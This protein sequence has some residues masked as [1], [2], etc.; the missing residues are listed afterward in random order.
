MIKPN[1][2]C[3]PPKPAAMSALPQAGRT[4]Q[5]D[6]AERHEAEP[7]ERHDAHREGAAGHDAGAVQQQPGAGQRLV[8]ARPHQRA[9]E[10]RADE[11][12]AAR[13]SGRTAGPSRRT[14]GCPPGAPWPPWPSRR[15]SAPAPRSPSQV[16]S[17]SA[18]VS[19]VSAT[20]AA[21][22]PS[23]PIATPPHPGTAVNA[24]ARS[25]VWRMKRRLSIAR[26][27]SAGSS[28]GG[29]GRRMG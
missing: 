19:R 5:G 8:E 28:G 3:S 14:P 18:G 16:P 12:A 1:T 15:A 26:A 29:L 4:E 6:G 27:W 21:A 7:H 13:S 24:V 10:Q 2:M 9:G 22:R 11:R 25:I 20:S 23:A 17:H